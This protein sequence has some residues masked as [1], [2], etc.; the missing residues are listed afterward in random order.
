MRV[1][2]I[3]AS[4]SAAALVGVLAAGFPAIAVSATFTVPGT[5]DPFLAGMPS[6]S[7]CCS[8]DSAP[9]ESPVYAG[10]VTGGATLTFTSV[11]GSVSYAGGPPSDP[12]DGDA[13]FLVDTPAYEGG[14]SDINNIAGYTNMP[15]DALIGVFLNSSLPT[16]NA[17]PAM[18]DFTNTGFASLSPGLQQTFFIGDGLTGTGTGS[19]QTFIVPAGA[20]RLYLATVDGFGW[21][22]NSGAI[23][24]TV[25]GGS[26]VPEPGA[27]ALMLS[28]VFGVGAFARR[29]AAQAR[30]AAA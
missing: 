3:G 25:N 15:V 30:T 6:G 10:A 11:S 18:L 26:A 21:Y 17:A 19:V 1:R 7:T 13:G 24:V 4:I 28:G 9:A 14:A 2:M 5:S 27:W 8:G 23:T 22:N 12:P 20:T 16:A 29:R